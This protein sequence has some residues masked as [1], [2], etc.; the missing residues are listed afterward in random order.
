MTAFRRLVIDEEDAATVAAELE[1][2]VGAARVAQHRVLKALKE[3][4]SGLLDY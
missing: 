3:S 2:T 4:G 1:M